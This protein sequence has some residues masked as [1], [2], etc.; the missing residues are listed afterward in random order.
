MSDFKVNNYGDWHRICFTGGGV[1][2]DISDATTL[3]IKVRRPDGTLV[4]KTAQV[5]SESGTGWVKWK[6]ANGDL[7]LSGLYLL[8][9][10]AAKPG[11]YSW[12]TTDEYT[13]TVGERLS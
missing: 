13:F 5:D 7:S 12:E 1:A 11:T 6:F 2:K 8:V 3:Q 9:G 4:T 10:V